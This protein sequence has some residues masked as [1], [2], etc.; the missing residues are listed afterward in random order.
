MAD[1]RIAI[2]PGSFD[3]I[4]LGHE[5][6]AR[7][8]VRLAD[9]V[10]VAVAHHPSRTKRGLFSVRERLEIIQ[11]VF[12][13]EPGIT[14]SA[15]DGLLVEY[16]RE[17]GATLVVRG[18]RG[19]SDLDYE[20]RMAMMNRTLHPDL[21]TVFLAPEAERSFLSASLIREVSSHGGD[22]SRFVSEPVLR[23][24]RERAS[25]DAIP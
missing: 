24:L 15:F 14:A 1:R 18:L 11:E 10:I 7:R 8:A 5:D 25:G 21:E 22:V 6:I 16:A 3:P 9:Q 19:P 4:T 20:L 13:G 12:A 17:V 2:F 23:R